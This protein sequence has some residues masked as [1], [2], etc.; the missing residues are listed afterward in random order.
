[1]ES[2]SLDNKT[3]IQSIVIKWRLQSNMRNPSNGKHEF[4]EI[5]RNTYNYVITICD[6]NFGGTL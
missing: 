5:D 1:M 2:L 4:E 3:N 6:K